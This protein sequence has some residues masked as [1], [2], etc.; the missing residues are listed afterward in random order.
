[1]MNQKKLILVSENFDFS[2]IVMNKK[3]YGNLLL[4]GISY[5]TLLVEKPLCSRFHKFDGFIRAHNEAR[6]LV[7]FRSEKFDLSC[8]RIRYLL[9]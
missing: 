8:N 3:S 1:M 9:Q 7:L 6:Y 4:Y 5:K 2:N